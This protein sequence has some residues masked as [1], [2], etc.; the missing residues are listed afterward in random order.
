MDDK[1]FKELVRSMSNETEV[2]GIMDQP[3]VIEEASYEEDKKPFILDLTPSESAALEPVII[4]FPEQVPVFSLR[5]VPWNYSEP[6]LQIGG[7]QILKEEVSAVMRSGK[8]A[9]SSTA[10][11]PIKLSNH[12]STPKPEVN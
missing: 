1:E 7:K 11:A 10:N 9:S 8:I 3:F 4:E 12:E 6:V 5:Q 2:F